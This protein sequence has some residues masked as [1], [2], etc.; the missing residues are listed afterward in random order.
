MWFDCVE[1]YIANSGMGV[2]LYVSSYYTELVYD[3]SS[4]R[5]G[6]SVD[7][8]YGPFSQSWWAIILPEMVN[9]FMSVHVRRKLKGQSGFSEISVK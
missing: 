8:K 6:T 2:I 4:S 1:W 3:I 5:Y 9:N 7:W